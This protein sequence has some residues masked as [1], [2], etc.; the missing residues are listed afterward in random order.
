[1]KLI[2][3]SALLSLEE[4]FTCNDYQ[5]KHLD[6]NDSGPST[7]AYIG[8]QIGVLWMAED[9]PR[10]IDGHKCNSLSKLLESKESVL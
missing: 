5:H 9:R 7:V 1:M 3:V 2:G 10:V 6:I 4:R 8:H